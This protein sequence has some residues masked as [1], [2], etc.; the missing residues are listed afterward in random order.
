MASIFLYETRVKRILAAFA[1]AQIKKEIGANDIELL[2]KEVGASYG[3]IAQTKENLGLSF[4]LSS[5]QIC[6]IV[7]N[8]YN[9]SGISLLVSSS[10]KMDGR[11]ED[12]ALRFDSSKHLLF[13]SRYNE[14]CEVTASN[15][16]GIWNKLLPAID[17]QKFSSENFNFPTASID[18]VIVKRPFWDSII[19]DAV[20]PAS[21][22][23]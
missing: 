19:R 1:S 7:A 12:I 23:A 9:A 4:T 6:G 2:I 11:M 3:L 10:R 17:P 14:T 13:V 22:P 5:E 8:N 20:N 16:S 15:H 18:K 21:K